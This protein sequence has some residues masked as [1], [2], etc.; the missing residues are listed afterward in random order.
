MLQIDGAV[1]NPFAMMMDQEGLDSM[2]YELTESKEFVQLYFNVSSKGPL[3]TCAR[4]PTN[5]GWIL[6]SEGTVWCNWDHCLADKDPYV[7]LDSFP[8]SN[9]VGREAL[10]KVYA[11]STIC[12]LYNCLFHSNGGDGDFHMRGVDLYMQYCDHR[13]KRRENGISGFEP[14]ETIEELIKGGWLTRDTW[15]W[16]GLVMDRG[17]LYDRDGTYSG[18]A[19]TVVAKLENDIIKAVDEN[20]DDLK[21]SS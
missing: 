10:D 20:G 16:L 7:G 8:T 3:E 17:Y 4:H 15:T 13:N 19:G 18:K 1:M 6:F 11:R 12:P 5:W 2:A 9:R 14:S 21:T